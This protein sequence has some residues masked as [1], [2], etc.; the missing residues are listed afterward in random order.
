[1]TWH[2]L[3][4]DTPPSHDVIVL[5]QSKKGR[6]CYVARYTP[7]PEA[8]RI[9]HWNWTPAKDWT[10]AISGI[11]IAWHLLPEEP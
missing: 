6:R 10:P 11:A 7:I 1:M 8:Q 5:T 9:R 4:D 3:P 2:K